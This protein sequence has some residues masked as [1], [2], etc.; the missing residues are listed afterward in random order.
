MVDR[1]K[2]AVAARI[3]PSFVIM[4]RTDAYANEGLEGAVTRCR[5]YVAAGADMLFPEALEK[6]EQYAEFTKHFPDVPV[7]AN[8]T[9]FGRTPMFTAEELGNAGVS[10]V[11]YPLSAFRA[12]SK[13]ALTV[14]QAILKQGTQKGVLDLM[15][16]RAELYEYLGYHRYEEEMDRLF[17]KEEEARPK[18]SSSA[19]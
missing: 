8:I 19:K 10:I 18:G 1:L 6:L 3:D 2:A 7:L 4:A 14:Y 11:L 13:A 17:G 9:E 16:T 5:A 15:Q 12:M